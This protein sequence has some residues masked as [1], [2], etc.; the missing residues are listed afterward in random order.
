MLKTTSTIKYVLIYILASIVSGICYAKTIVAIPGPTST[1]DRGWVELEP[2]KAD[3]QYTITPLGM[4]IQGEGLVKIW[5]DDETFTYH[6]LEHGGDAHVSAR[7]GSSGGGTKIYDFKGEPPVVACPVGKSLQV[8][9]S[10]PI[11]L[12]GKYT[13]KAEYTTATVDEKKEEKKKEDDK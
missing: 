11:G 5:D 10:D 3:K 8:I 2:G 1:E 13:F 6:S 9:V 12:K 7:C 4:E